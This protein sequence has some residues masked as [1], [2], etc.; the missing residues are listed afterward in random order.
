[1]SYSRYSPPRAAES[2]EA[3]AVRIVEAIDELLAR[4]ALFLRVGDC[5]RASA[6]SKRVTPLIS[7][8]S[9]LAANHPTAVDRV[10]G[11]VG[12][13]LALRRANYS[14]LGDLR[15]R[16]LAERSRIAEARRLLFG[17]GSAYASRA[18]ARRTLSRLNASV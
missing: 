17:M 15:E 1:M 11:R 6:T 5:V 16:L 18:T 12:S 9:D 10:R 4:E 7:R 2:P 3:A 8:L 13:L 14:L